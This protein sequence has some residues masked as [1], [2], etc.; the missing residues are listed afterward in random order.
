MLTT[1]NTVQTGNKKILYPFQKSLIIS[2]HSLSK[3]YEF[4]KVKY[5]VTYIMTYRLNQDALEHFFGRIRQMGV[6]HQHPSPVQFKYRIRSFLVGKSCD[7]LG[8]NHN[9]Q[10]ENNDI[11]FKGQSMPVS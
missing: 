10:R 7:L 8:G 3:L 6:S 5:N 1:A 4:V 9:I 2:C 11:I